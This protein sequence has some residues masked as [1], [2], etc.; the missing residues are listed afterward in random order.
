LKI[1]KEAETAREKK[2][3]KDEVLSDKNPN[4]V[5]YYEIKEDEK[6][7]KIQELKTMNRKLTINEKK[8]NIKTNSA[9]SKIGLTSKV[10]LYL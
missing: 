4:R 10:K 2:E 8:V 9:T 5:K 1:M 3:W 6:A 7:K